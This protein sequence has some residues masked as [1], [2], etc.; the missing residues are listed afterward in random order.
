MGSFPPDGNCEFERVMENSCGISPFFF[1]KVAGAAVKINFSTEK[2]CYT[3]NVSLQ[4]K[5]T[6]PKENIKC[7]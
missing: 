3:N 1:E 2:V 6:K 4:R 7:M 5:A